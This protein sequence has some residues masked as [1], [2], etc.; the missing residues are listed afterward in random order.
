[1]MSAAALVAD[2]VAQLPAAMEDAMLDTLQRLHDRKTG[3]LADSIKGSATFTDQGNGWLVQWH[4]Q[5]G[6]SAANAYHGWFLEYGTGIFMER[7][8]VALRGY[9]GKPFNPLRA[10]HKQ[11]NG[12]PIVGRPEGPY[13]GKF[14]SHGI[15]PSH[16]FSK[17]VALCHKEFAKLLA[18]AI[19]RV[20]ALD[21][22][23]ANFNAALGAIK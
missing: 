23:A 17:G 3:A 21:A 19:A 1:M 9:P 7:P 10:A 18:D 11:G 5:A 15:K 20:A 12:W 6:G 4:V 14:I 13:P 22:A 2:F 16:W 8:D